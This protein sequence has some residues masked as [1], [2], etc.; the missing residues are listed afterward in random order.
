MRAA[1]SVGTA[2]QRLQILRCLPE[3]DSLKTEAAR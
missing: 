2:M 3:Q 1:A